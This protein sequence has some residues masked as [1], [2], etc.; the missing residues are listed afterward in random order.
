MNQ[1][2]TLIS[3]CLSITCLC[4]TSATLAQDVPNA[5]AMQQPGMPMMGMPQG[6]MP[7]MQGQQGGM[8]MMQGQQG[9]MPM[10]PGYGRHR[11]HMP[12]QG[13][14]GAGMYG[15]QH[16]C[17]HQMGGAGKGMRHEMMQAHH[18]N[19]EERLARIEALLQKLV[20]QQKK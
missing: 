10:M 2:N 1:K 7:M 16:D 6:T 13:Q 4:F 20:D 14:Q 9:G 17:K 19:M 18:K 8:P 12:G 11:M 15:C 3:A 5:P